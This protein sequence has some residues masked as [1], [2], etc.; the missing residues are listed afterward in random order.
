MLP[1]IALSIVIAAVVLL[2]FLFLRRMM[3]GGMQAAA[4]GLPGAHRCAA[5][6]YPGPRAGR[7]AAPSGRHGGP[8]GSSASC[9]SCAG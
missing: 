7:G 6:A 2:L 5:I 4:S 3:T 1:S 9:R 8:V